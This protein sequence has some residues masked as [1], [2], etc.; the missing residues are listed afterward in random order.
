[1]KILI[2]GGAGYVGS[3]L[4]PKTIPFELIVLPPSDSMLYPIP[5]RIN[6]LLILSFVTF[7]LLEVVEITIGD[8]ELELISHELVDAFHF[9]VSPLLVPCGSDPPAF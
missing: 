9:R 2:T 6:L 4:V 8:N 3:E 1:M 7:G 5:F